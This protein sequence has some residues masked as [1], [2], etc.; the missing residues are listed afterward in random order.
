MPKVIHDEILGDPLLY[1][2][3]R[4]QLV[5]QTL[6]DPTLVSVV[7]ALMLSEICDFHD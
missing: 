5:D 2:N 6:G 1:T 7:F 3:I 4:L